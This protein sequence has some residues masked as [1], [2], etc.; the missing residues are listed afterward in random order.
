MA[1]E[2]AVRVAMR[3]PHHD[4]AMPLMMQPME[5]YL[6]FCLICQFFCLI[7]SNPV[8]SAQSRFLSLGDVLRDC[9]ATPEAEKFVP[10]CR[11]HGGATAALRQFAKNAKSDTA[12]IRHSHVSKLALPVRLS[13]SQ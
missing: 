9:P 13:V 10:N 11:R 2:G 3:L 5:S 8:T 7:R 12:K 4:V 1:A 6:M